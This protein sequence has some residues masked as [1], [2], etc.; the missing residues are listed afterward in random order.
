MAKALSSFHNSYEQ[1]QVIKRRVAGK[2]GGLG[3]WAAKDAEK[4]VYGKKDNTESENS[5]E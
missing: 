4:I 1:L 5:E 2:S 3:Y